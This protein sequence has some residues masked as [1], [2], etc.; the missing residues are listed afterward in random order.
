MSNRRRLKR[1]PGPR[2]LT[3]SPAVQRIVDE[4][5]ARDRVYFEQ[6]PEASSYVRPYVPG[7][8]LGQPVPPG[9]LIRVHQLEPGVRLREPLPPAP[10]AG[11]A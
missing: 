10:A 6:H 4:V 1:Q 3:L 8:L 7:E 9:T 11:A 2:M 5:S